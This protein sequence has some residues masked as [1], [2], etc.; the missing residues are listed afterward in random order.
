MAYEL[1]QMEWNLKLI[2]YEVLSHIL[3]GWPVPN[4][5]MLIINIKR[6]RERERDSVIYLYSCGTVQI[7]IF[8]NV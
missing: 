8:V 2:I 7:L 3:Y 5:A 1:L 6:E 4:L